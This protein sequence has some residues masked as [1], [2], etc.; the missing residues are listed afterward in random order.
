MAPLS[1]VL[2]VPL[3]FSAFAIVRQAIWITEMHEAAG[4]GDDMRVH[5][6]CGLLRSID[7]DGPVSQEYAAQQV[8]AMTRV[9]ATPESCPL[10]MRNYAAAGEQTHWVPWQ[11]RGV[12]AGGP[13][14][15]PRDG[16]CDLAPP[17][18]ST[19]AMRLIHGHQYPASCDHADFL[20]ATGEWDAGL[21]SAIHIK[22]QMLMLALQM[23]RV[24]VDDPDKMWS[25]TNPRTCKSRDWACYF[26]PLS[27]C[28]LPPGWRAGAAQFKGLFESSDERF[29]IADVRPKEFKFGSDFLAPHFNGKPTTWWLQHATAYLLRPNQ[30]SLNAVCAVWNCIMFSAPE[31]PRPLAAVFIRGG[32]K[33]KEAKLHDPYEYFAALKRFND[34]RPV[35]AAYVGTD[36]ARL[37]RRT[38]RDYGH[39]WRFFW[40]GY[41]RDVGGLTME[42]VKR[43]FHTP[44][45]E[46]QVLLSLADLYIALAA[47]VVVGTRSSNWCRLVE[48]MR[49]LQGKWNDTFISL[50]AMLGSVII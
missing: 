33:H 2:L 36:D 13:N 45:A 1:R 7:L 17:L 31:P 28:V 49:Q 26:A 46:W 27:H 48:D 19:R 37:M 43:R 23:G 47:D 20:V 35:A 25:Y 4:F 38:V 18:N 10:F 11:E 16:L 6:A 9:D 41:R 50:D 12:E 22:A 8:E 24:L 29:M 39:M 40:I 34:T 14:C 42:E 44:K 15:S 3:A 21:G 30:R 32:D 5:G